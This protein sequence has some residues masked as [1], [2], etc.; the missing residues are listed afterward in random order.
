MTRT[1]LAPELSATR[2]RDSC[3]IIASSLRPLEDFHDSPA[4]RLR[5]RAGLHHADLVA[6]VHVV[7]LVVGVQLLGLEDELVVLRVAHALD[8]RDD[9]GLVHAV[10]HDHALTDL[11]LDSPATLARRFLNFAHFV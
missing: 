7:R 3:W 5:Q 11:A 9:G 8:D 10:G 4:L 6:D 1:S 2:R